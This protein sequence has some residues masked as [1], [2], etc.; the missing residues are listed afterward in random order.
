MPIDV[1]SVRVREHPHEE[2]T[3]SAVVSWTAASIVRR[4]ERMKEFSKE[5]EGRP[6]G[7]V[8]P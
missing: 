5:A 6:K 3:P 4:H 7:S 8:E 1:V 2:R